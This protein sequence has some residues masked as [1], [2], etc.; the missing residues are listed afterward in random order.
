MVP[1]IVLVFALNHLLSHEIEIR[2]ACFSNLTVKNRRIQKF[3]SDNLTFSSY[4]F[5]KTKK[6]CAKLTYIFEEEQKVLDTQWILEPYFRT[7][8]IKTSS[9]RISCLWL[10]MAWEVILSPGQISYLP[11]LYYHRRGM[12]IPM[13]RPGPES[14]VS[15]RSERNQQ[16]W[17]DCVLVQGRGQQN[18]GHLHCRCN[19]AIPGCGCFR[20]HFLSSHF[21]LPR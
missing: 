21:P 16:P 20:L 19:S 2:E 10:I 18:R 5:F 7:P 6:S 17:I 4:L 1:S 8:L 13:T 12:I 14:P 9:I 11:F 3:I 15:R